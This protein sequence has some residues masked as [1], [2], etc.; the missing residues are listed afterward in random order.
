[1]WLVKFLCSRAAGVVEV[2]IGAW[3]LM[4]GMARTTL[5]GLT[6][7][8]A[9]V[10]LAVTGLAGVCFFEKA[11]THAPVRDAARPRTQHDHT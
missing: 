5:G 7:T 2:V 6:M 3:L 10:V 1:M 11:I 4:E 9:G 8:M